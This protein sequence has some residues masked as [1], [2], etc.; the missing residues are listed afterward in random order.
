MTVTILGVRH[1]GP[2]SARAVRSALGALAPDTIL[3]EGPPEADPLLTH[4]TALVPPV[5]ILA[6]APDRPGRS[7]FWPFADFSPEWQAM[8]FA[9]DAGL[10]ARFVDLAAATVLA[11]DDAEDAE[12]RA[13]GAP[14]GLI[15]D[16]PL[17]WLSKAAGHD[18]PERWWEDVVEHRLGGDAL[19]LFAAV[20]EAMA[21][22]RAAAEGDGWTP[23]RRDLRREAAMRQGIRAAVR[24]GHQRIAV[25]CGA[26]HVPALTSLPPARADIDLLRGLPRVKTSATWVPWT[27]HRLTYASGYGAGVASPGWYAH[28]WRSQ[29][30]IAER[31]VARVAALLREADLAA[32]PASAVETVRLAEAVAA[33]RGRSLPGLS[34]M[35]DAVLAVLCQGD[36]VP[37]ALIHGSLVVGDELGAVP[38]DVPTVPLQADFEATC[39]RLRFRPSAADRQ[40]ELDL[41]RDTDLGRSRL[42]HR[43]RLLGIGW[44]TVVSAPSAGTFREGWLL[45][46][47]P[48]FV[49]SLIENARYGTTVAA[50][51]TAVMV[52]RAEETA[53]F[54][55]VTALVEAAVLADLP[56][57]L[58]AVTAALEQRSARTGDI[59]HLMA[60]TP[61]LAR[62]LRYGSVRQTDTDLVRGVL[63]SI[64]IRICARLAASC[65]SLDS[66]AASAMLAAIE[67]ADAAVALVGGG[68]QVQAWH[69]AQRAVADLASAVSI[70]QGR[71]VRLLLDAGLLSAGEAQ[72][73]LA[74]ALSAGPEAVAWLEGFVRGSGSLLLRDE[75]LW[76]L[77]DEWLSGL[78]AEAFDAVL[79]LLR[80]AFSQFTGPERQQ[81]GTKVRARHGAAGAA[82]TVATD[83]SGDEDDWDEA[84]AQRVLDVVAIALGGPVTD[85]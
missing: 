9:M 10:P 69:A 29:D 2:G 78:S 40:V 54:A 17:G 44:G 73:R 32:S 83:G 50:A 67:D 30:R 63:D 70:L 62:V 58:P 25:V 21:A 48:E 1:H 76:N 65:M 72:Q 57:A 33:L 82:G 18:D 71:C 13:F 26:W 60:A 38:D 36:Q 49:V 68:E 45:R 43:L 27:A 52:E 7:A 37:L 42:L 31:W 28:L 75:P 74:R 80:R 47:R 53:E 15:S 19:E 66:Q 6:H 5:A 51:A 12:E 16:D 24:A 8:R 22:L 84:R 81:M 23:T 3:I 39:R 41:R 34:E 85:E 20:A 11:G 77:L 61:P 56:D 14:A 64:L 35:T 55:Q 79:P 59:A 4:V 46:W